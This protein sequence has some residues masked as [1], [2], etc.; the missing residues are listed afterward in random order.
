MRRVALR[1]LPPEVLRAQIDDLCNGRRCFLR[2]AVRLLGWYPAARGLVPARTG[3]A[4]V[5]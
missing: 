5:G 3:E 2:V 1:G 4:N